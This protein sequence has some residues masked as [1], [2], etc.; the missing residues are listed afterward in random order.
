MHKVNWRYLQ[1]FADGGNAG[2]DGG[3][4][5]AAGENGAVAA[6]QQATTKTQAQMLEELGVP[7]AKIRAKYKNT[8]VK[9][10]QSEPQAAAAPT[11]ETGELKTKTDSEAA[12][13]QRMSWDEIKKDPEYNRQ[14]QDV[15]QKR[16]QKYKQREDELN[17]LLERV[18][19]RYGI[20]PDESGQLDIKALTNAVNNDNEYYEKRALDLGVTPEIAKQLDELE[21]KAAKAD[22]LE[23][24]NTEQQAIAQHLA[25]LKE[26]A[27]AFKA[28]VPTFDLR[29]ELANPTF[30]RL[31]SPGVALSVEDAYYAVHRAEIQQ[32]QAQQA[33]AAVQAAAAQTK[34]AASN[35]IQAGQR[36]PAENAAG[37][38]AGSVLSVTDPKNMTVLQRAELRER[39]KRAAAQGV[40]IMPDGSFTPRSR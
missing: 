24:Q 19:Q 1:L 23:K 13:P 18:A 28:T 9:T 38:Q 10:Q 6:E 35:S 30:A 29:A 14:M 27:N 21:R 11:E 31:T 15:I 22:M 33:R 34:A 37:A 26:Q 25:V 4:G 16:V 3:S 7:S 12:V 39:I 5:N 32:A 36:R 8:A 40:T 20:S 17:G 2:G